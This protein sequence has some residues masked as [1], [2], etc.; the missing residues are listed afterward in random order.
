MEQETIKEGASEI[1]KV[2]AEAIQNAV[3]LYGPQAV[4][5]AM[6]VYRVDAAQALIE[7]FLLVGLFVLG[8]F[9]LVKKL[10]PLTERVRNRGTPEV[11][12]CPYFFI[13][14]STGLACLMGLLQLTKVHYWLAVFGYPEVHM[15][16]KALTAGGLM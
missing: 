13:T 2:V 5:L 3:A 1:I 6:V 4:D 10:W 8:Q 16:M 15:A 7:G 14:A 11:F 12:W 9:L